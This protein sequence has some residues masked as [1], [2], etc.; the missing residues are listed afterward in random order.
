M[1]EDDLAETIRERFAT[2]AFARWMGMELAHVTDGASEIHLA[3]ET[4]HLNPGG[5]VHGGII[6]TMLDAAIGVALRTRLG[7]DRTHVTV[8]LSI[9][10]LRPLRAG[11]MVARARAVHSGERVGYGEADLTDADG[12]LLARG[13]ATF[14]VVPLPADA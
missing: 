4:H 3:V 12:A 1:L 7:F 14:L 9:G 2:S 10:Y 13:T 8:N 5:I 11:A 6:A